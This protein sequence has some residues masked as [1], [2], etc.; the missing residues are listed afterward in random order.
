MRHTSHLEGQGALAPAAAFVL[1]LAS[2]LAAPSAGEAQIGLGRTQFWHDG[3]PFDVFGISAPSD[4]N[5]YR[6]A[7][8]DFDQFDGQRDLAFSDFENNPWSGAGAVHVVYSEPGIGPS[9]NF[10]QFVFDI[11]PGPS[12]TPD[13]EASDTFGRA[14]A[15]G[16][17]NGDLI[18]DLAIGV[19]GE[20][21]GGHPGAGALLVQFGSAGGLTQ[22]G[23]VR[24]TQAGALIFDEPEDFDHFGWALAALDFNADG[25]DDL[26][27]GTPD[28]DWG[29]TADAGVIHV[30]YGTPAGF[31]GGA[32]VYL[33]GTCC[34]NTLGDAVETGD[35]FG[36]VLAAGDFNH[37]GSEDVAIGVPLEDLGAAPSLIAN[38]GLVHVL[39][40]TGGNGLRPDP[41]IWTQSTSGIPELPDTDDE[42]GAS[43][44]AGDL[45]FDSWD[46]LVIG[47]PYEEVVSGDGLQ[48]DAGSVTVLR[49]GSNGLT[50]FNAR[51][52]VQSAFAGPVDPSEAG[53]R[54]G[55]SLGI[56]DF[57]ADG[58][59]DLA[60]GAPHE[61][62]VRNSVDLIEAGNV[63]ILYGAPV[64]GVDATSPKQLLFPDET[65]GQGGGHFGAA[66]AA[67]DLTGEGHGD[68]AV[69]A[70][71]V[72]VNGSA[73]AGGVHV[74]FSSNLFADGFESGG[75]NAWD[76]V[77]DNP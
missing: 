3:P 29:T 40:G 12:P 57:N 55:T 24:I 28:E 1:L 14:L 18:E 39:Y 45:T 35:R 71:G 8:G 16:D 17:F 58:V 6:I 62:F 10:T 7:I 32:E 49:G 34:T 25:V 41:Q 67:G 2:Q 60:I 69:G 44:V 59:G 66:L 20:E 73:L 33:Q 48:V 4:Q 30:I 21:V 23:A 22:S 74:F 56:A 11:V 36:S 61:S 75:T 68:L 72:L 51:F 42:Y 46:E 65:W 50:P 43:L 9:T 47:A 63:T 64:V 13:R 19:P 77:V 31:T 70:P 76:L 15:V 37:D 38:A 5:G 52:L 26:I 54:F 53:D 27:I